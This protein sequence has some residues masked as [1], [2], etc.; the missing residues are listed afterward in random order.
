MVRN[1]GLTIDSL[2][3]ADIVTAG[4][5]VLRLSGNENPDLFWAIRGGG[6]NFGVVTHLEFIAQPATA[7][8]GHDH[9]PSKTSS[10]A[11][12]VERRPSG[13]ARGAQPRWC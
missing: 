12:W 4:G 2:V 5:Q 7:A 11:P 6:G 13:R 8:R 9:L 3:A 10:P 1:H